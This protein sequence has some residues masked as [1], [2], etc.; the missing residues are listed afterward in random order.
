MKESINIKAIDGADV[1]EHINCS[2]IATHY[3]NRTRSWF[4]QRL[5]NN[6]VNGKPVGFSIADIRTLR[7]ALQDLQNQINVYAYN[8]PLTEN[9]N[10][11]VYIVT[12]Q[13]AISLI[14]EQDIQG[15]KAYLSED[16]T[17]IS[18]DPKSF[19]TSQE[20]TAFCDGISYGKSESFP[21]DFLPLRSDNVDDIPFITAIK[22]Y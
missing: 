2:Y 12:D 18:H 5:N 7:F 16:Q 19:A 4:F 22:S 9:M 3:F 11:E 20:A 17:I 1:L 6:A 10:V 13:T 8:L 15:F 21:T 14:M